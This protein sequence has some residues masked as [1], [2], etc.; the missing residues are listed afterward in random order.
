M[1]WQLGAGVA[2]VSQL[3]EWWRSNVRY[4]REAEIARENRYWRKVHTA[5]FSE[6]R[7]VY[8]PFGR[9]WIAIIASLNTPAC[10]RGHKA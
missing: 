5:N 6:N 9:H 10:T 4:W 8:H 3:A 1:D 2:R 7:G